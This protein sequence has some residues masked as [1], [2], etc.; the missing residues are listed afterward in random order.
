MAGSGLNLTLYAGALE[1]FEEA[2]WEPVSVAGTSGGGIIGSAVAAGMK[3]KDIQKLLLDF[4]PPL[5]KILDPSWLPF[6]WV[7]HWGIFKMKKLQLRL[8]SILADFGVVHFKDTEIPFACFTTNMNTGLATEWSSAKTPDELVSTRVVDGSRLP[9]AMRP[10][11]IKKDPHRDGGLAYN[12]P[13][14][15]KFSDH[16]H[17]VPTIGLLFR[18]V[19]Q[20]DGK[21]TSALGDLLACVGLLLASTAREHVEDAPWANTIVLEPAGSALHFLKSEEEALADFRVGYNCV[22]DWLAEYGSHTRTP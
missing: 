2:G 8:S 12:Y 3:P 15:F 6:S 19:A 5:F 22:K 21:V 1:A 4:M 11:W 9:V 13:I 10:A 7:F 18:G 20:P 14:D 16:D 17:S